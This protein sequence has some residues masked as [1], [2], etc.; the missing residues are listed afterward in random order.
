[1]DNLSE[2]FIDSI[3]TNLKILSIVQINE[4]LCIHKGHLQIDRDTGLQS[5]KRWF[6]RDSRDLV[7]NFIKELIRN[8]NYLFTK[9]KSLE[10]DEQKWIITR[11]LTEMDNIE[12]GLNNLKTTYS[13]DPV[14]IVNIEN[15]A[16]KIKEYSARGKKLI[17]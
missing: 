3:I 7:L 8:I 16:I 5:I 2:E 4:K 11:I 6:Y 1:M 13:I 14:T 15:I 9:V 12:N 10:K 17:N